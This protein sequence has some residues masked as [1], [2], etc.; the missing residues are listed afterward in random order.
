MAFK[1]E[2]RAPVSD[3]D[4]S[5]DSSSA[6]SATSSAGESSSESGSDSESESTATSAKPSAHSSQPYKAPPGFKSVKQQSAPKSNVSSLLSDLRGKQVYHITAPDYLPLSK[7]EEV[8][9]AKIMQ[10]K[11]VLKYKGV[12]YGIPVESIKQPGVGGETLQLYDQKTKTYYSTAAS[13]IPS[14]HIQELVDLPRESEADILAA[15]KEQV[16]PP[17]KQ[18]KNLKMRFHPVGSGQLP[19]ETIGSSSEESEGEEEPTFKVPKSAEKEREERKRK[20]H[21]TEEEGAPSSEVSRKKSKK[22]T[23]SQEAEPVEADEDKKS[24]KKS[25]K[26]RDE[27]K[28]KKADKAA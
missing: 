3:E 25:S 16:K 19:P 17:R 11:P 5:M 20:Q 1:S 22:H 15:V 21:P 23:S 10:G 24:K 4:V 28:R 27:K 8:S 12:Q 13:N 7:V 14:Y 18:P 2:E 6:E 26:S 9:L